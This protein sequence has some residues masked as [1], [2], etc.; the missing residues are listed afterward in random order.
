[1]K[2]GKLLSFILF[3]FCYSN[4]FSQQNPTSLS[5]FRSKK[6]STKINPFL[7][8]KNSIIPNTV[9]IIG[10]A[11][12]SYSIDY[13]NA[14]IL[15]KSTN[16][17]DSIFISYRVFPY[18][19]NA[20]TRRFNY[21]SIRFNFALEK[22]YILKSNQFENKIIDFGNIN[23]NGSFGRGI[24]IG[25]NQDAVVNSTLNL[26]LNGYIG[27]SLELTA[28]ISDNNIPIQPEG[29]TQNIRDFDRIF[30]Q[31]KKHGWQANFGDI[32]VRQSHNYFLNFSKRLQG[33][34]FQTDN[35][36]GKNIRNSF[37]ASGAIS[38]GN[39]MKDIITPIEGNQ[40]PYKLYG[41]N[42]ELYFAV[43]AGTEKVYIDGEL[44]ARGEDRDYVIDY[45]TAELTFTVK[46]LITKDSRIQVEF[47]YSNQN[48]LNSMIYANDKIN[49]NNKL[50]VSIG[51]YSNADAKNSSINQTL[52]TQ[53][54]QF[55]SKIGNNVD[56][57]TYPN[58]TPDT[59]SVN[60]ILYKKIDT[61]I[62]GIRDTIYV[63]SVNQKDSLYNLSFTN[64]GL[65]KGN[66]SAVND[67]N[68]NGRVFQFVAPANGVKQ[69]DWEPVIFLIPPKKHELV[70]AAAEYFFNKNSS[71]K[72]EIAMSDYDVNT[73]STIEKQNDKGTAAKVNYVMQQ[74]VF[75]H[76][77]PGIVLQTN[78]GYEYVQDKF[79]PLE[80]LRNVE[81]NR[82]W[83]LPFDAAAATENLVDASLQITDLQNNFLKYQFTNYNRSDHYNG[84]RN[85]IE[86]MMEIKGWHFNNK[87]Y[88]TNINSAIQTGSY[89]RPSIDLYRTFPS[90]DNLKIGGGY[91][92]E[93]NRQLNKKFDTL[94]P[95]SFAFNTWQAYV[96]SSEKKLNKWAITY[97][98]RENKIPFQKGLISQDKSRNI[99]LMTELMKS[100]HQQLRINV[101][102]RKLDVTNKGYSN[103]QS[104]KSL[105]GRAEYAINEWKGFV[106]GNVL[107]EL[108]SGQEQKREY[109]YI[110]VPAGQG[111]YTWNDYNKDGIPQLNEFEVAIYEDQKKWVRVFTPTNEYVK[112][113]YIQFN[114]NF[115]FNP[116][117]IISRNTT[118]NFLKFIKKFSSTSSLQ[119]NKKDISNGSFEF[120]PLSKKLADTSLI[121]LS[122]FLSNTIY[123]NRKNSVWGIDVTHRLNNT[124]SLLNYGFESNS[125]RD[126]S[127]KGRWN[128]NRSIATTFTN[129]Y[130]RNQLITPS[131]TNRNYLVDE[132]SAE[133]SVSYIYKSDFR[134]SIIYTYD[135]KKNKTGDFEKAINNQLAAE[136]KY[137]VLSNGTINGRF[138]FNHISFTGDANS[139]V[140]Y[141]LLDG[142][143]PGK[144]YLWNLELTKRLAGNIE[145]NLQYEG[146]KPGENPM[147]HTGRVSLRA[148]F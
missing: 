24:S 56:S 98:E 30:L 138:S 7:L 77:K 95:I 73:F 80:T 21:D 93:N 17:P 110:E 146:R 106:Q 57:A 130:V 86:N 10:I 87:F 16:L 123:F 81:F 39:Y 105:L 117:L 142:L 26:Q 51:A 135:A 3:L 9:S 145:L 28:A 88:V 22:P 128:L 133:P 136:V 11:E 48:Y 70:T 96:K 64:V 43:L 97:S 114:Y 141:I 76:I 29:N 40:G 72:A 129:K 14:T 119:I 108:G 68:A 45:N 35:L 120:N 139:T 23:Y 67:G 137:N 55:L 8:D 1:L 75:G 69:G 147:I 125:L 94:M 33:G 49:I 78:V 12:S 122:S 15:W 13:I 53:Q 143:L 127:L 41:A 52:T 101:T 111:Y 20:V 84:V 71:L 47:E 109:T 27:D 85:S 34:S 148:I 18:K 140:G 103:E 60:R 121:T 46:H 54:K 91:S 82:D 100:E 36:I 58:A 116:D 5:N 79:K 4:G 144:N 74:K 44:L 118:K 126:L 99:S 32:D 124:K 83:S 38:K 37:L 92:S 134:V 50:K 65:G 107:Y 6:I 42:N 102:Y 2:P 104:D 61:T 112:A 113:N 62:N 25:N 66:Y 31:I 59:F 90:L 115:S 89:V 19:L 63:Y 131:F 132:V